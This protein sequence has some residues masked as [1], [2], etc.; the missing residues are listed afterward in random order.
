MNNALIEAE[1]NNI[2]L[3]TSTHIGKAANRKKSVHIRS[4]N[5]M[6]TLESVR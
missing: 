2:P 5:A 1:R 6:K 4:S 3:Y